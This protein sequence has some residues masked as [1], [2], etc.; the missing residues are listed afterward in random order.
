MKLPSDV[1]PKNLLKALKKKGYRKVHQVGSHVHLHHQ[2]CH[3]T[4]VAIHPKPIA[5]GTLKAILR[6][7]ELT[8]DELS[9]LLK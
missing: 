6:Q 5:K 8:I 4:Q 7:T 3:R 1:R 9:K 2:D